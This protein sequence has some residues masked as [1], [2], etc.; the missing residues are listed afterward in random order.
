L[1]TTYKICKQYVR[2]R[3][4]FVEECVNLVDN[5]SLALRTAMKISVSFMGCTNLLFE[6]RDEFLV[7]VLDTANERLDMITPHIIETSKNVNF[8]KL[9]LINLFLLI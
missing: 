5:K 8:G 2:L 4:N 9:T 7:P 1:L 3:K 6:T